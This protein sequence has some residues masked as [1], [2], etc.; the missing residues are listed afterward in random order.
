MNHEEYIKKRDE[1][2]GKYSDWLESGMPE[3]AFG[4]EEAAQAI[5]ALVLGVIGEDAQLLPWNGDTPDAFEEN[6]RVLR[7]NRSRIEQRRIV[8]G[9]KS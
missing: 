7:A 8:Q 2:L 6:T 1:I 4:I 3:P 5:D 9:D